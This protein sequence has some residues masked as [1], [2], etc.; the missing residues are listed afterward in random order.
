MEPA[1]NYWWTQ[2]V[3]RKDDWLV[4]LG[5]IEWKPFT[6]ERSD[7][8]SLTLIGSVR[9][10]SRI[11]A[12]ATTPEGEYFQ[13]NGDYVSKLSTGQIRKAVAKAQASGGRPRPAAPATPPVVVVKRRRVVQKPQDG[14]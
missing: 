11:G 13:V 8:D 1:I 4:R 3:S 10:G 6:Y 2:Y 9:C 7:D 5:P 12:L 14:Q